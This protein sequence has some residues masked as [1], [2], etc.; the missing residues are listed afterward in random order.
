M[1]VMRGK[2]GF[3]DAEVWPKH[4]E[5]LSWHLLSEKEDRRKSSVR[6]WPR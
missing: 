6:F 5:G 4:L 2:R 3:E 1:K